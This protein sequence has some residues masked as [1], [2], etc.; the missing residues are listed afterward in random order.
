M[1]RPARELYL[2]SIGGPLSWQCGDRSG[3]FFVPCKETEGQKSVQRRVAQGIA[4]SMANSRHCQGVQL[5]RFSPIHESAT[6]LLAIL[7]LLANTTFL[8][9]LH[10]QMGGHGIGRR[11]SCRTSLKHSRAIC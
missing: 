4:K 2:D 1:R 10:S 8:L 3:A 6:Y 5:L 9:H 11:D 7:R